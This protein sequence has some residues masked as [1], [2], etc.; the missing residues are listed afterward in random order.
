LLRLFF[1][2]E[3]TDA[4]IYLWDQFGANEPAPMLLG[5]PEKQ[6]MV[7]APT[8]A[9]RLGRY[10]FH[11]HCLS[12]LGGAQAFEDASQSKRIL[13]RGISGRLKTLHQK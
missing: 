2:V 7:A 9:T 12:H 1:T 13:P 3:E 8:F 6:L 10:A 11:V 4:D 5:F